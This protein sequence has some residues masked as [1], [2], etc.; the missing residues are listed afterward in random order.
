MT[1]LIHDQ[2]AKQYLKE[3]L[4]SRGEV[5]TSR[6]VMGEMR[7]IDVFFVP[8]AEPPQKATPLGLLEKIIATSCVL[9]PFRNPITRSEIRSCI[10][11][12]FDVCGEKEREA[13][14]EKRRITE[15]ELPVLW[16]L[17]PTISQ[18]MLEE[19]SAVSDANNWLEGVYS[20]RELFRTKIVAIHQLPQTPE[21][22]WLRM[23]GKG[24]VQREVISELK[25]L[26][27]ESQISSSTLELVYNLL[28]RLKVSEEL[29]SPPA[30][31]GFLEK[32]GF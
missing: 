9:E 10:G 6:D 32:P 31:P 14:V 12:L 24:R 18:T 16:I 2:F 19:A 4:S 8:F 29:E 7:Q 20:L 27:D 23:L 26:S 25:G 21:T 3:L 30:K 1:R 15:E 11:K 17:T 28:T 5:E 22:L 13:R